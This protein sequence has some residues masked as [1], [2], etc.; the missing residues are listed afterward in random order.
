MDKRIRKFIMYKAQSQEQRRK[1]L[2]WLKAKRE[3]MRQDLI[4]SSPEYMDGQPRG[5]G[6][7]GD[8]TQRK[9]L[10]LID[11]DKRVKTLEEELQVFKDYENEILPQDV[12]QKQIYE[13]TVKKE[14]LNLDAKAQQ[15]HIG[16]R[17]LINGR[18]R[19]LRYFATK[20][21]EYI[22]LEGLDE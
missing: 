22:D 8:P 10:K 2:E 18:A 20:L 6:G 14:C 13:E 7:T 3:E 17:Q 9:A 15:I 4:D 5:K 19:I 12:L 1:E 21:G 11:I 16:R